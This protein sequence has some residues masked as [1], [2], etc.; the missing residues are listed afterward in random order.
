M[1]NYL[2]FSLLFL[3]AF[4][5]APFG[6]SFFEI[7]KV[8]VAE[9]LVIVLIF[10]Q[11]IKG[12]VSLID[13]KNPS[14]SPFYGLAL[15]GL[16]SIVFLN[17]PTTF[18]GNSF[19]LQG[20]FLFWLLLIFSFLS[21]KISLPQVPRWL[22]LGLILVQGLASIII[23]PNNGRLI[24]TLGEPN[25]LAGF[26]AFLYPIA[27]LKGN[28]W[29]KILSLILVSLM[30]LFS[31]SRSGLI[32]FTIESVFIL[33]FY[34]K[35]ELKKAVL[36]CLILIILSLILPLLEGGGL[37]EKRSEIW[38]T[39][40][41]AGV[42]SPIIGVGFGN[43]EQALKLASTTLNNNVQYQYVDSSHNI[44]LDFWVQGGFLGVSLLLLILFGSFKRLVTNQNTLELCLL[45]GV[46]TILLFN[47]VSVVILVGFWWLMRNSI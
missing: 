31:G 8:I 6:A 38:I 30:I 10:W 3:L 12:A 47:P 46:L 28:R 26:M 4:L 14:L 11:T 23:S 36:I 16:F 37:F 43:V 24:G 9:I 42:A 13:L 22:F 21:S 32:A 7:P 19:R 18:F 25:S 35:L 27:F 29:Q 39:A 20:V 15:L 33:L 41:Q 45:L 5:I 44:L 17:T 2:V 34:L 40:I 1:E